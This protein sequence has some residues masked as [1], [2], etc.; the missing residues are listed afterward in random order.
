MEGSRWLR[1][2]PFDS[3]LW[4]GITETRCLYTKYW[5]QKSAA[6]LFEINPATIHPRPLMFI[7]CTIVQISLP[8]SCPR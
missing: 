8:V 1:V 7:G 2:R 5:E 4:G 3:V 6:S